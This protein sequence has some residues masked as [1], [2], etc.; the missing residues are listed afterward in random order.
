M[1]YAEDRE[2][3]NSVVSGREI[4]CTVDEALKS[5]KAIEVIYKPY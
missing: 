3:L 4:K 5:L 1:F 2:F